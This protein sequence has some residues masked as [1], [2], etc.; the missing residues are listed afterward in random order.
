MKEYIFVIMFLVMLHLSACD[1]EVPN[2]SQSDTDSCTTSTS[3]AETSKSGVSRCTEYES[4]FQENEE[5]FKEI[6]TLLQS[7]DLSDSDGITINM[8]TDPI[9]CYNLYGRNVDI[10]SIDGLNALL[11]DLKDI[12]VL[13]IYLNHEQELRVWFTLTYGLD[14]GSYEQGIMY[15][16]NFV[17]SETTEIEIGDDWYWY[18][19][20]S[21]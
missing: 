13:Q 10:T 3:P 5:K 14:I 11:S 21:T 1:F 7:P 9:S 19:I 18:S 15:A 20:P 16:E 6:I 8:L 4:L 17:P 12:G 2:M